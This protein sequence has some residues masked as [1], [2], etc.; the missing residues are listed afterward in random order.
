MIAM[1]Y[2]NIYVAQ[3]SMGSSDAQV[4]KA[5]NEADSYPGPSL[6]IAYSHCIAHGFNLAN[7]FEQQ[8][9]AVNSGAWPLYRFDPRLKAEGKNPLQLDSKAPSVPLSDFI[10]NETRFKMLQVADPTTAKRLLDEGQADV[11]ARWKMYEH[12][13]AMDYSS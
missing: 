3:I 2:G 5:F 1:T 9:L 6:I 7:G 4:V 11:K 13:A 8:K 10:Y 12:M